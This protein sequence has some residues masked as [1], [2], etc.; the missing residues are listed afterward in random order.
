MGSSA[1]WFI[2]LPVTGPW[3]KGVVQSAPS[4]MRRF[5]EGDLHL[6]VA[7]LGS[8]GEDAARRAWAV[9]TPGGP[10]RAELGHLVPMGNPRRPSA[11]SAVLIPPDQVADFMG[12]HRVAMWDAAGARPDTRTPKPHCTVGRPPKRTSP[13]CRKAIMTWAQAQPPVQVEVLLDRL[14]LYTWAE[15]R[16]ERQ[17]RIVEERPL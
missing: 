8:C 6:T 13:A 1:N 7:F 4:E 2:G 10:F 5:A 12:R 16:R 15:D 14:A 9:E 3:L 17:F 11:V